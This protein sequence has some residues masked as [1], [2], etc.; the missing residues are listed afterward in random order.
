MPRSSAPSQKPNEVAQGEVEQ[1][2]I[3]T[4]ADF[5]MDSGS[6]THFV[7]RNL[8]GDHYTAT[9]AQ[10]EGATVGFSKLTGK[11]LAGVGGVSALLALGSY[12]LSTIDELP[13][14]L[15]VLGV[16]IVLTFLLAIC[17]FVSALAKG[18]AAINLGDLA[19]KR[20]LWPL[21]GLRVVRG[22]DDQ[23][24]AI[25]LREYSKRVRGKAGIGRTVRLLVSGV[26]GAAFIF[27]VIIS[28]E[29]LLPSQ[30]E[31]AVLFLDRVV[32]QEQTPVTKKL[33]IEG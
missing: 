22:T 30:F 29:F 33:E 5:L 27:A 25:L 24:S 12:V 8:L 13:K 20:A 4:L 18:M 15:K 28:F 3:K 1:E 17:S 11:L 14:D 31:R 21:G 10:V 32:L 9:N 19:V 16:L 23:F 26:A 2:E 6:K 7:W